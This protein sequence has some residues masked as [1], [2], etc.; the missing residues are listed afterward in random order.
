MHLIK[1]YLTH[2]AAAWL[3]A[4]AACF[5]IAAPASAINLFTDRTAWQQAVDTAPFSGQEFLETFTIPGVPVSPGVFKYMRP[6]ALEFTLPDTGIVARGE[7]GDP[8][9]PSI[10]G[11]GFVHT[12]INAPRLNGHLGSDGITYSAPLNTS[13]V[14]WPDFF[15]RAIW[16]FPEPV[17]AFFGTF[18]ETRDAAGLQLI[19]NNELIDFRSSIPGYVG[20]DQYLG[21]VSDVPFQSIVFQSNPNS[22]YME[23][24]NVDNF[25]F[26]TAGAVGVPEPLTILGAAT[27]LG[28]GL[29]FK[30]KQQK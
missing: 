20:T 29:A 7:G 18:L 16:T 17:F 2:K 28:F 15:D 11:G 4:G 13:N 8:N 30:H 9:V 26:V 6:P 27:A 14:L 23:H 24:F 10:G 12:I 5:G 21:V 3:G 22:P 1:N 19:V 25:Y